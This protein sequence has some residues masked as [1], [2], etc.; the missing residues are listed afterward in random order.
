MA[1]SDLL[2]YNGAIHCLNLQMNYDAMIVLAKG[3]DKGG[4]LNRESSLRANLAARMAKDYKIPYIITSGWAYRPDCDAKLADAFK[5][6]IV[7]LGVRTE[8]ILAEGN[9][10][11]TVGDAVF[12]RLNLVEP[13]GLRK[14]C[15]VTSN[16]HV[17]RTAKIFNFIYG[18]N[19]SIH[20]VGADVD[21]DDSH[22][23]RERESEIAFDRTFCNVS[24]GDMVQ[25]MEALRKNH[26]LYNGQ[27]YPQI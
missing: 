27:V 7:N 18:P 6:Y 11:D 5:S 14:F 15:V 17:A 19:F 9:S 13:L 3:M 8:Q 12:S 16:Y 1:I 23:S 24:I 21:F 2:S 4:T 26:P 25:I 22:L 20:V 10:R